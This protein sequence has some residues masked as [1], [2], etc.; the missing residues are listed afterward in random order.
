MKANLPSAASAPSRRQFLQSSI[1]SAATVGGLSLARSVH[2][3]G[4]EQ[5]AIGVIGCGSRGAGAVVDC[6]QASPAV[7]LVAMCDLFGERLQAK[8]HLLQK[9]YPKQVA[10]DDDHC[11]VGFDGYR[12]VIDSSDV[13]LVVC[14]SKF[15]PFYAEAAVKAGKHV[16]VEKP[17]GIDPVG[18]RRMKAV[19]DL[20]KEKGLSVL[21]GLMS[22]FDPGY[23]ETVKRIHDG[24][25]GEVV[26][27]QSMYLRAPYRIVKRDPK[28]SETQYQY[29]NWYHFRWL[30]GDDVPQSLAH[31]IDRIAWI[32]KEETPVWAF[33]LGGRSASFGEVYGDMFDHHT[34]VYEYASGVRLF[35]VSRTQTGCYDNASDIIMGAKG[36][37]HLGRC[38]I[39]GQNPWRYEG[40]KVSPYAAE[41]KALVT[42]VLEG[43]PINSGYHMIGS[44]M[45]AVMGQIAC[46]TGRETRWED[47]CKSNLQYGPSPEESNFDIQPPATPDSPGN[48]PVPKPGI[49]RLL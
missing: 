9:S 6:M 8:R 27:V 16:F 38:R 10:V 40:P 19:C 23:R 37:C 2:A 11:F 3:Q 41:Q 26:A 20:A 7:K 4:K 47:V 44:T 24:A 5:I 13:V 39:E 45:T 17:H 32:L 14:A 31:N 29:S 1:L 30:S 18:V 33:G 35:A 34:V 22:R 49:T 12:K 46:Y 48:Y 42:A 28:L 43:K 21:S 25:I 15:H 36:V